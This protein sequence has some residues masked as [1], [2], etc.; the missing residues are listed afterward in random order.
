MLRY[1]VTLNEDNF[2]LD[3]L[4]WREKYMDPQLE[5]ASGVT[6][7]DAHLE[8]RPT[9]AASNSLNNTDNILNVNA[10]NVKRQGF[11]II[12]GK[13]YQ[14][15]SG[16]TIVHEKPCITCEKKEEEGK[17]VSYEYVFI[18]GKYF[19]SFG[20]SP[21]VI[22]NV[23]IAEWT[24]D[25]NTLMSGYTVM[26]YCTKASSNG[27]VS[28]DQVYWI[29]D[30]KVTIDDHE[31]IY[32][33]DEL[34]QGDDD[35]MSGNTKYEWVFNES[36]NIDEEDPELN[37]PN[38]NK[39]SYHGILKY[40]DTGLPLDVNDIT[41]GSKIIYRHENDP[42]KYEEVT[43]F[44]LTKNDSFEKKFEKVTFCRWY[45]Y[46]LYKNHY[47]NIVITEEE[48]E[49]E[50]K[51]EDGDVVLVLKTVL[52]YKCQIP[53]YVINPDYDAN[54]FRGLETELHTVYFVNE[55]GE[56]E[57]LTVKICATLEDLRY[58]DVFIKMD[59]A[60][61]QVTNDA[62]NA[63]GGREIIIYLDD[64][65]T[66]L[67]KGQN[68]VFQDIS[69]QHE[70]TVYSESKNEENQFIIYNG[71]RYPV[72]KNCRD[73]M[74][75]DEEDENTE[76][77]E[78][79][80]PNGKTANVDC[81][82]IIDGEEVPFK[83]I[84]EG[85]ELKLQRYG[86]VI[87]DG[88]LTDKAQYS[89]KQYDGVNIDDVY[90]T[91]YDYY[92]ILPAAKDDEED[93]VIN[94]RYASIDLPKKYMFEVEEVRGSSMYV[95][96][97]AL[98][99][100][101]YSKKFIDKVSVDLCDD[102]VNNI[103]N[104]RLLIENKIFGE[105]HITEDLGFLASEKPSAS[106]DYYDF[107]SDL[108]LYLNTGYVNIPL[109]LGNALRS[110][111]DR[112]ELIER[113]FFE[114][115]KKKAIN[116]IIDMEKDIYVPKIML[117]DTYE[118]KNTKFSPVYQINL[119]FHFRTRN[120]DT[121]KV[122][123]GDSN[124]LYKN[125]EGESYDNWF[126]TDFHPYKEILASTDNVKKE[127]LMKTSD[128][129]GLLYFTNDDIFYQK[130]KVAKSF[131]RLSFYDSTDEQTQ[132]LLCSLSVFVDEHDLF[133]KFIDNS[134]KNVNVFGA[135]MEPQFEKNESGFTKSALKDETIWY[136]TNKISV[137]SECLSGGTAEILKTNY[138]NSGTNYVTFDENHRISSRL[139]IKNKY[140]TDTSSEGFY[141][142]I[143]RE[144]SEKLHPK[145][146][147][148]K[149]EYNHAGIG[150][151]IPFVIPMKWTDPN[152]SKSGKAY[153]DKMIKLN[154]PDDV[155]ELKK[156]YQLSYVKGQSYIPLYAVYD[157]EH[158]E[159]S[160]IFDDRYV[161]PEPTTN[162]INLNLFELKIMNEDGEVDDKEREAI[163]KRTQPRSVINVNTE[164]FELFNEDL[165]L[166]TETE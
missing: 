124:R 20:G 27:V 54:D 31:Y 58:F 30:G 90:Y 158:K 37:I 156:G 23:Q 162:T 140:E 163:L 129:M 70:T 128:P 119:N 22:D 121:W 69:L 92:V 91:V 146:I 99:H 44:I 25:D 50:E 108:R 134:R 79:L 35:F 98:S 52:K 132:T 83:I 97:P 94:R 78:I 125:N 133:K 141:L 85:D 87:I 106:S 110:D 59:D 14:V 26:N 24:F 75:L 73:R 62:V 82:V 114:T 49:V 130:Q 29:E 7:P 84:V 160:Y 88:K 126:V 46:V 86:Q 149:V 51:N 135:V 32:D 68:V 148:M 18:N 12:K 64:Q 60:R 144:Y 13:Q 43:K 137:M 101:E 104:Y 34:V 66:Q 153:P 9:I 61:F 157:F 155:K 38:E 143:F 166:K 47:C 36:Y 15:H 77:Y 136:T 72:I 109:A 127:Q 102:V 40:G 6:S 67:E 56:D 150:K 71:K 139:T 42:K 21:F 5:F 96:K 55:E 19:Y 74:V 4:T 159:Y 63:N 3:E 120:M 80:Y 1:K 117:S 118:C 39:P 53:V 123:D 147:Y 16:Q 122:N 161:T 100:N 154:D 10:W 45:Y 103:A 8:M 152:K 89:I 151:I 113:D 116:P 48:E 131:A 105:R 33:K 138:V 17:L 107:S 165:T 11:I 41:N 81:I 112:S 115:E 95:C 76:T 57:E 28:L 145:P 164:M 65:F 2:N 93:S 111:L 142:Y